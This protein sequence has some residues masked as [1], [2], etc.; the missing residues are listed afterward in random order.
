M[1][2]DATTQVSNHRLPA[3]PTPLTLACVFLL[4]SGFSFAEI[5]TAARTQ[6]GS[7]RQT[8]KRAGQQFRNDELERCEVLLKKA[9]QQLD[10][11]PTGDP[12]VDAAAKP[13]RTSLANALRILQPKLGRKSTVDL[14]ADDSPSFSLDIADTLANRCLGCH[15]ETR[16][17]QQLRLDTYAGLMRGGESGRVVDMDRAANSLIVLKLKGEADG[18]RMP[19]NGDPV[20]PEFIEQFQ[21][22]IKKGARFDGRDPLLK[23]DRLADEAR[24]ERMSTNELLDEARATAT[25]NWQRAFPNQNPTLRSTDHLLLVARDETKL[26]SLAE[27]ATESFE[28]AASLLTKAKFQLKSPLTIYHVPKRYDYGEFIQM[29]DR[30]DTPPAT[31]LHWNPDGGVGYM[32]IGPPRNDVTARQSKKSP[33]DQP[34]LTSMFATMLLNRWTAPTWYAEGAGHRMLEKIERSHPHVARWQSL[35]STAAR[36]V[37]TANDLFEQRMPQSEAE[38]VTWA[39]ARFLSSDLRRANKLHGDLAAGVPFERAFVSAFGSLPDEVCETWL[40]RMGGGKSNNR[41]NRNPGPRRT[42]R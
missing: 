25:A 40:M 2:G 27:L 34:V 13:L 3:L 4:F 8:L 32:V 21:E 29:V 23:L 1:C 26:D 12:Q 36:K 5:S 39:F 41:G 9:G 38:S 42:G 7:I 16:P 17:R 15:G 33:V 37:R 28:K 35:A 14:L 20:S 30:R 24:R 19:P 10:R 11:L 18:D 22:W 31:S 6:L